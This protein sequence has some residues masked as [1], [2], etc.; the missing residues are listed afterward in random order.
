VETWQVLNAK[1]DLADRDAVEGHALVHRKFFELLNGIV[2]K[3]L[4]NTLVRSRT[5][6]HTQPRTQPRTQPHTQPMV[7]H[8]GS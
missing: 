1:L 7:M 4:T 5:Q 6:P 2:D 3:D 8:L